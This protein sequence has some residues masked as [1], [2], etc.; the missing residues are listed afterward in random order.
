MGRDLDEEKSAQ[1]IEQAQ[2]QA[3]NNEALNLV[4]LAQPGTDQGLAK[5]TDRAPEVPPSV[6]EFV[7]GL[8]E[9]VS[10]CMKK[11][12]NANLDDLAHWKT[13]I[14]DAFDYISRPDSQYCGGGAGLSQEQL[15]QL[16]KA[17]G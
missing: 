3:E 6:Q 10:N 4:N 1:R 7:N 15:Q 5:T 9:N 8:G 11:L 13:G 2:P 14:Q 16:S 12:Q 17:L